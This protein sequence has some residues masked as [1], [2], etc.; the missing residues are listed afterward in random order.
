MCRDLRPPRPT[1]TRV[2][3]TS[4]QLTM[5]TKR[6]TEAAQLVMAGLP[7]KAI[8]KKMGVSFRAAHVYVCR[9]MRKMRIHQ[10]HLITQER[11]QH[12]N[13]ELGRERI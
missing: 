11:I 12:E 1:R 4:D 7:N 2:E 8:A 3:A 10:R 6:E 13:A 5:L 9:V